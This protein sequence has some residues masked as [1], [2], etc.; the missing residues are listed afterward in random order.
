MNANL[1][2][3]SLRQGLKIART[4]NQLS[5]VNYFYGCASLCHSKAGALNMVF[6][7]GYD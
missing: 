4:L 7:H 3:P 2:D 6:P 1:V 5:S